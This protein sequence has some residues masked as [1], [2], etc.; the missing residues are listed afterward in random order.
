M[1]TCLI[2]IQCGVFPQLY[3]VLAEYA[4]KYQ[5]AWNSALVAIAGEKP[6]LI[7]QPQARSIDKDAA[8][9]VSVGLKGALG[10]VMGSMFSDGGGG[11]GGGGGVSPGMYSPL[12]CPLVFL[13]LFL[14][15]LLL[16]LL[17]APLLDK[18]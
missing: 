2:S 6:F 5:L 10:S 1:N 18:N 16:L 17:L 14:L 13:L 12:A 7:P 15:L 8:K 11:G 9:R 4:G 3:R